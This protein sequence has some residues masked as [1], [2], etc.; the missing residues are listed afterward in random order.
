MT[1]HHHAHRP[2]TLALALL[3]LPACDALDPEIAAELELR[4]LEE[5]MVGNAAICSP[6]RRIVK[7]TANGCPAMGAWTGTSLFPGA[8]SNE[9]LRLCS[10]EW[11][12][13]GAPNLGALSVNVASHSTDCAA[14]LEHTDDALEPVLGDPLSELFYDGVNAP[15]ATDLSAVVAQSPV[16]VVVVD[17]SPSSVV[18]IQTSS[19]H[20][21]AMV[22]I[23]ESLACPSTTCGVT[24]ERTLALPR[25][26]GGTLDTTHGGYAG[27]HGDLTKAIYAAANLPGSRKIINLSLGWEPRLFGDFGESTAI[28]AVHT[29]LE[30]AACKGVLVVAAAGNEGSTPELGPVLPGGWET[31]SAPTQGR[32]GQLGVVVG[33]QVSRPLVYSVGGLRY[34]TEPMAGTREDGFPRLAASAMHVTVGKD[35]PTLSGTSVSTAA[36]SGAAA[37]LWSYQPTY[38]P[39]QVMDQLYAGGEDLGGAAEYFHGSYGAQTATRRLD[40]CDA[41]SLS[42]GA[43]T[44]HPLACKNHDPR[45]ANASGLG[46][47]NNELLELVVTP[48]TPSLVSSACAGFE[49]RAPSGEGCPDSVDSA[50]PYVLPQPTQPACPNCTLKKSDAVVLASLDPEYDVTLD[51]HVHSV[52]V[53][54]TDGGTQKTLYRLGAPALSSSSFTALALG[55]MPTH[56]IKSATVTITFEEFTRGQTNQL[57]VLD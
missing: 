2:L 55:S 13:V 50:T 5:E 33:A 38:S 53:E 29:A 18:G 52:D 10:Y 41:L 48:I 45:L 49:M 14:V 12:G 20:G 44:P 23:I 47:V 32:C 25:V 42:L 9:L 21:E 24:V 36:V 30:Y 4:M 7:R 54:L 46:L 26:I 31:R 6:G 35:S 40:V 37:L 27:S 15:R 56:V 22:D 57:V 51:W 43:G 1:T 34:G 28:D 3:A 8:A 19:P 11:T 16:K 17:A 39:K